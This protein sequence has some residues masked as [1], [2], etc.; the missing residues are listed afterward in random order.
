[1][2]ALW[3]FGV[4]IM[5]ESKNLLNKNFVKLFMGHSRVL[6]DVKKR[7][8]KGYSKK[9][10]KKSLKKAGYKDSEVKQAF[11]DVENH[12]HAAP[13][14]AWVVAITLVILAVAFLIPWNNLFSD[15]YGEIVFCKDDLERH[16]PYV[17]MIN[18]S[19]VGEEYQF[20][21]TPYEDYFSDLQNRECDVLMDIEPTE[22]RMSI[23][24]FSKEMGDNYYLAYRIEDTKLR[25]KIDSLIIS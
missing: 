14:L 24:V 20:R 4:T 16:E 10:I 18:T 23:M 11:E 12:K 15:N 6:A 1:M 2:Q 22:D 19:L 5:K 25:N 13:K 17:E 21:N 9:K 3:F 7:L 8:K